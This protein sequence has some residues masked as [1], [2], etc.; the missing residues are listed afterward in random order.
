MKPDYLAFYTHPFRSSDKKL[1]WMPIEL[2]VTVNS[3][4]CFIATLIMLIIRYNITNG[5]CINKKG[6][7]VFT[8]TLKYH[9]QIF[10][11]FC[12]KPACAVLLNWVAFPKNPSC[13]YENESD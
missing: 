3:Y 6:K 5:K 7:P 2:L 11:S 10:A 9:E 12:G 8:A 1:V 4:P 13:L